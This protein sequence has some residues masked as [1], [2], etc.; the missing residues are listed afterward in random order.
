MIRTYYWHDQIL[1]DWKIKLRNFI[2]RDGHKYFRVG[3]AGDL[4]TKEIIKE[5]YQCDS[6]NINDSGSR[7]LVVGSVSHRV[8]PGDV[9][10]G[11]G[12][13]GKANAL[14]LNKDVTIYGL[15]GPLSYD[16]FKNKGY[17]VSR[18]RF[19]LDP[20]LL[21][22]F[23]YNP[24]EMRPKKGKVIF[25]PHY[26]ERAKYK[27][28]SSKITLVD[29]DDYPEK[30]CHQILSAEHVFSSS[31][32]GIIFSHALFR[33]VTLVKPDSESMLKY[34]DYYASINVSMPEPLKEFNAKSF[35]GLRLSPQDLDFKKED[36]FFPG[37]DELKSRGI[38]L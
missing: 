29:I 27:G 20:G 3:N 33:P 30:V 24:P 11:V 1:P 22:R 10:C 7:L 37:V 2:K 23:M 19:M 12:T 34:K 25:I 15:R 18:V 21:V 16:E 32:H 17:D 28:L 9:L 4:L 14:P 8:R 13:Q 31:L 26:K 35:I 6:L 5:T 36:F 38:Y